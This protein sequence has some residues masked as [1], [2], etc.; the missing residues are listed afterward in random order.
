MARITDNELKLLF[1]ASLNELQRV[2][3]ENPTAWAEVLWEIETLE[4]QNPEFLDCDL[5]IERITDLFVQKLGIYGK[6]IRYKRNGYKERIAKF[7]L[8]FE[9]PLLA[10]MIACDILETCADP[11]EHLE[12]FVRSAEVNLCAHFDH[13]SE[14]QVEEKTFRNV[15]HSAQSMATEYEEKTRVDVQNLQ[16]LALSLRDSG[17]RGNRLVE[18][19]CD[20]VTTRL[21]QRGLMVRDESWYRE[22]IQFIMQLTKEPEQ[23]AIGLVYLTHAPDP[24][25]ELEKT[26]AYA[27]RY[28]AS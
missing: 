27:S 5:M 22:T 6:P 24:T 13:P 19:V 11:T 26:R 28:F 3:A 10:Q 7:V 23:A 8:L 16:N 2:Q 15:K 12:D 4:L 1:R 9:K 18:R 25:A 21:R 17:L 14:E 20:E